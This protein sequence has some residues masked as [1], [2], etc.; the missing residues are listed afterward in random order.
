MTL[1]YGDCTKNQVGTESGTSQVMQYKPKSV[2][3]LSGFVAAIRPSFE[4][5]KHIFLDRKEFSYDIP[6]FDKILETSDNLV[7]YQ[8]NIM[9]TLVYSGFEEDE[10][11]SLLKAIAKKKEGII[12]PIYERFINGFTDKSGSRENA[13]KVWKIIESSVSYG[14]NSSH[15][16]SVAYDSLY[17]AY[18]KA[19]YPLEYYAVVLNIYENNTEM[20]A[21]IYKELPHFGIKVVSPL[22]GKARS[23]YSVD[24]ANNQIVKGMKSIKFVNELVSEQ[25]YK[26]S[27][28]KQYNSFIDLLTDIVNET[29]LNARQLNI[30]IRLDFFRNFGNTKYL[31]M[32]SLKFM[33]RY[34]KTHK[35]DTKL[36][37]IEEIIEYEK[38]IKDATDYHITD[39][40]V[41]EK[42][43]L[44]YAVSTDKKYDLSYAVITDVDTKYSPTLKIYLVN[45]GMEMDL[46]IQ[47]NVFYDQ[48]KEAL[49]NVGELIKVK[50][51]H[52]KPKMQKVEGKWIPTDVMQNWL[53]SWLKVEV[54]NN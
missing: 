8:E 21:K 30:L 40:V 24:K 27:K 47:K 15:S 14:F 33:D 4:S 42:E 17:G 25:L 44:G 5:M 1:T 28:H 38:E 45:N 19:N 36:K 26:L 7:L 52:K 22:F 48:N 50:D 3:E 39:K 10:T 9:E 12:E 29:K 6:E 54:E 31:E 49:I 41:F 23:K 18:L 32:L 13:E 37:R 51:V 35:E 16:L 53:A 34:K 43:T 11:Y 20:T 46:K 2:R